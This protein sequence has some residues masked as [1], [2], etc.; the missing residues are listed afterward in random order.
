MEQDPGGRRAR[1]PGCPSGSQALGRAAA[2]ERGAA[3]APG[4]WGRR[5]GKLLGRARGGG[6]ALHL[7]APDTAP[8]EASRDHPKSI[9]G[10]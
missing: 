3:L 4:P 2:F 7:L 9:V 8:G 1:G 6:A 5:L 10:F